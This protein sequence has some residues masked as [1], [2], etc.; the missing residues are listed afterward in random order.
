MENNEQNVLDEPV[1]KLVPASFMKRLANF[2]I[3]IIIFSFILSTI[4][5]LAKPV[6]PL[7]DKIMNQ[8]P[9]SLTEQL[10]MRFFYGLYLSIMEAALKGKSIGKY[11]TGTRAVTAAGLPIHSQTAFVRGLVRIIPF[12]EFSA[13]TFNFSPPYPFHDRFSG[14]IVIDEAASILPKS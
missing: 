10:L 6:Y 9:I 2:L 13:I 4:M 5:I 14:S 7:Y 12:E 8:Q 3:D 11:L 1:I